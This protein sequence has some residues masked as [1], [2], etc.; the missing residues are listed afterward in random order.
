MMSLTSGSTFTSTYCPQGFHC[1]GEGLSAN[2]KKGG[3]GRAAKVSAGL[4]A[5][6]VVGTVLS[7]F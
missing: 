6:L 3:A 5:A 1:D 7:A 4:V 2:C